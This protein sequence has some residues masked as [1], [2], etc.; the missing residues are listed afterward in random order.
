VRDNIWEAAVVEQGQ[1]AIVIKIPKLSFRNDPRFRDAIPALFVLA[2]FLLATFAGTAAVQMGRNADSDAQLRYSVTQAHSAIDS[3]IADYI[4]LIDAGRAFVQSARWLDRRSFRDF[5]TSLALR[6][7]YPGFLGLGYAER[8]PFSGRDAFAELMRRS[9]DIGYEV[10][11]QSS[12]GDLYP[13]KYLEPRDER[14]NRALGYDMFGEARRREAMSRARD[15]DR[16]AATSSVY[17]R[18]EA[19]VDRQFGFLIYSPVYDAGA[20][21]VAV[22]ARRDAIKGFVYGAFRTADV[23]KSLR[24]RFRDVG[25]EVKILDHSSGS[26]VE[27]FSNS[28]AGAAT[29][30]VAMPYS[31]AGQTWN[32]VYNL[33]PTAVVRQPG[34]DLEFLLIPV[35]GGIAAFMLSWF[36]YRENR[37]NRTALDESLARE[38]AENSLR[39][40]T[41]LI[42]VAREPVLVLDGDGH[43]LTWNLG[44]EELYGY[45]REEAI[46]RKSF[47]LLRTIFP[48]TR[49]KFWQKVLSEGRISCELTHHTRDN[50]QVFVEARLET[51]TTSEGLRIL[52]SDWDIGERKEA[53]RQQRLLVRELTHRVKNLL[54][55]VQSIVNNTIPAGP[56]TENIRQVLVS[57]LHALSR[58]Q[59]IV[60][61]S[62]EQGADL[63]QMI[64]TQFEGQDERVIICGDHVEANANFTQMFALVI[65]ELATNAAKYGSLSVPEGRVEFS[66][67][68]TRDDEGEPVLDIAWVERGGPPP[69]P[70][71]SRGFG[72]RLIVSALPGKQKPVVTFDPAGFEYRVRVPLSAIALHAPA[73][74]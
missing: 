34:I 62:N 8:V 20:R 37:A 52:K 39:L 40:Q 47:E 27:V 42:E 14:N 30:T 74:G 1:A 41:Q 50:R 23:F 10:T 15:E 38:K 65:H 63:L 2:S 71:K 31:F 46:G 7:R 22:A 36:V 73:T 9:G 11:T 53:E 4:T 57:R 24:T 32:I 45:S 3:A 60:T 48:M 55:V 64:R 61:K 19:G 66:L 18:Q 21:P 59:D 6:E 67:H 25:V 5:A 44:C 16:P 70:P 26:D 33:S 35:G 49:E 43:V 28:T 29:R 56:A 58:A 12:S 72:T 17:L 51:F 54:A 69:A 13:I 68:K